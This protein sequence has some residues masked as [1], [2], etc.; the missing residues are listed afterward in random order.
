MDVANRKYKIIPM[1][2]Q[3]MVFRW[4]M[5]G[6]MEIFGLYGPHPHTFGTQFS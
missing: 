3:I 6:K 5:E 1:F 4:G 2:F